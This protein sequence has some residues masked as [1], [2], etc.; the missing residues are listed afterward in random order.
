[1]LGVSFSLTHNV[2][3]RYISQSDRI[4]LISFQ[5]YWNLR[6]KPLLIRK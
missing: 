1:M 6:S 2:S 3:T 4:R 5:H